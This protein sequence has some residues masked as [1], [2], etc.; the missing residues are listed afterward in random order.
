MSK[1][2]VG[3]TVFLFF[4]AAGLAIPAHA[5]KRVLYIDSYNEGFEWS[6]GITAAVKSVMEKAHVNLKIFP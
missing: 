5:A 1:K 6:D 2:P 4:L 3:L